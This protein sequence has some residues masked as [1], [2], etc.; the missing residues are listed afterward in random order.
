M[1]LQLSDEIHVGGDNG[2]EHKISSARDSVTVQDDRLRP[3][4]HLNGT[5]RVATID[6]V[7]G[8]GAGT[9]RRLAIN[10]SQRLTTAEPVA[11]AIGFSCD[12]PRIGEEA[13]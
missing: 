13:F 3:A 1:R 7:A 9:K 11:D 10:E 8:V 6:N 4:G 5:I 12:L 2:P